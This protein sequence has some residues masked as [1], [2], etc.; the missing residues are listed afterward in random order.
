MTQSN[1]DR[2][3]TWDPIRQW[4]AIAISIVAIVLTAAGL[5]LSNKN[6][7]DAIK[8]SAD[9]NSRSIAAASAQSVADKKLTAY[10]DFLEATRM[11]IG[12]ISS[13]AGQYYLDE[14]GA[15]L[16]TEAVGSR[17]PEKM[18]GPLVKAAQAQATSYWKLNAFDKDE[19]AHHTAWRMYAYVGG[20]TS[21]V[22]LWDDEV[23]N[24]AVRASGM[25]E[26]VTADGYARLAHLNAVSEIERRV[27]EIPVCEIDDSAACERSVRPERKS[28][29]Y[30]GEAIPVP[31]STR[32]PK[33]MLAT[34][35]NQIR[36]VAGVSAPGP[37]AV[38]K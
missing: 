18:L 35:E 27:F 31:D 33:V 34:L 22:K 3:S 11:A 10:V 19:Q 1:S 26:N 37:S 30:T 13:F 14:Y 28:Y 15:V 23:V 29:A 36:A 4:A 16:P 7:V 38:P 21:V 25:G 12:E 9:Q 20:L 8:A 24:A 32:S 17:P 2:P 5:F 6:S